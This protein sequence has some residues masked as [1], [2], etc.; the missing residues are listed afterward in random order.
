M[1]VVMLVGYA[2]GWREAWRRAAETVA[3]VVTVRTTSGHV[4]HGFQRT[5]QSE[6]ELQVVKRQPEVLT[7]FATSPIMR[8]RYRSALDRITIEHGPIDL[9]HAH[10]YSSALNVGATGLPYVVSEHTTVFTR[11]ARGAVVRRSAR[12]AQRVYDGAKLV[13]PV[14]TA[15]EADLRRRGIEGRFRVVANP[16]DTDAFTCVDRPVPIHEVRVL[17][18]QRLASSKG[19]D[20]LLR[21]LAAARALEP[22]LKIRIAGEGP[23]RSELERLAVALGL[24]DAVT[25]LGLLSQGEIAREMQAAHVFAFPSRGDSFGIPVVEAL[26][27][28]LP[29]IAT[30]LGIAPDLVTRARGLLVPVGDVD[31]L[32]AALL[33]VVD[34]LPQ[35]EAAKV[36]AGVADTFSIAT[37]GEELR[38]VYE[39][40]IAGTAR[41]S[42]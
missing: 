14:S 7:T 17:F 28:G 39:L 5:G 33:R 27:T 22:R 18:A 35:Y 15:L 26:C 20:V 34:E 31:A 23:E 30:P 25:F 19:I 10:F 32:R 38:S 24:Q 8:R 21:A 9:L 37:I 16:I 1:R 4:P 42:D 3:S 40:A 11:G 2:P 41:T 12:V 6:Y 13:M 36:S 29:V